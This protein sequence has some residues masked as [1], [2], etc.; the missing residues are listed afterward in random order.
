MTT[1]RILR[2]VSVPP[3]K[4]P[5]HFRGST[6]ATWF[7]CAE[8]SRHQVLNLVPHSAPTIATE[9]GTE[10]HDEVL[11]KEL[12]R[13]YPWEEEFMEEIA[14]FQ[15][16]EYGFSRKI[17]ATEIYDNITGHPD[18]F[19]ITLDGEVTILEHKTTGMKPKHE[20]FIKHYKLP[21]AEFQVKIYCWIFDDLFKQHLEDYRLARTH[22]VCYWSVNRTEHT[23]E[24][25]DVY[26][27]TYYP[28]SV[29]QDIKYALNAYKNPIMILPPREWKCKQC[30][31]EHQEVCRFR[32]KTS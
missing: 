9:Q 13:R 21:M 28:V 11:T 16:P 10:L 30:P 20:S 1:R 17:G 22:A 18:D 32:G 26:P 2:S 12:G 27:I 5:D 3:T 29:E 24:L 25:I 15:N 14:Q 8:R 19:Q 7:W 23:V 4:F 31:K 6:L